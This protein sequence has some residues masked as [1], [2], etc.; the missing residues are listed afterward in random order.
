[1]VDAAQ[2]MRTQLS[3]LQDLKGH[4]MA[5]L[6]DIVHANH[7]AFSRTSREIGELEGMV[8]SMR[9]L[10]SQLGALH[11]NT[12]TAAASAESADTSTWPERAVPSPP[13]PA[14]AAADAVE[15]A[16]ASPI[17]RELWALVAQLSDHLAVRQLDLA[18]DMLTFA[19]QALRE[20]AQVRS[21]SPTSPVV[22]VLAGARSPCWVCR[23]GPCPG[24]PSTCHKASLLS[25]LTHSLLAS[26][27]VSLT[28]SP[29][30]APATS[31]CCPTH[32]PPL[33]YGMPLRSRRAPRHTRR[34]GR[35]MQWR[36]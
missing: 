27:A 15:K 6:R 36:R 35:G 23:A 31:E 19:E 16:A 5:E 22:L 2:G 3:K 20:E 30:T 7:A 21:P 32:P 13:P 33:T 26:P 25:L 18:E 28:L 4:V 14:A 24:T 10:H 12:T 9:K 11:S 34:S 1:V 29:F 8:L 17:A